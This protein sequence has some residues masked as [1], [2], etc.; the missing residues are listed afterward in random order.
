MQAN[1]QCSIVTTSYNTPTSPKFTALLVLC[2]T[3][4]KTL[5]F[6]AGGAHVCLEDDAGE[7][8]FPGGR[9]GHPHH[10]CVGHGGVGEQ[11]RLELGRG[12]LTT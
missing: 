8:E 2:C 1:Y 4:N 6:L 5:N 9:V 11:D 10:G 12:N 7:R 3:L